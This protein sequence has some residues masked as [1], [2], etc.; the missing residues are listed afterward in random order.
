MKY[1]LGIDFGGGSSKA[2]L[3][4]ENGE[5]KAVSTT[6]YKTYYPQSGYVEQ[7]GEDWYLALKENIKNILQSSNISA[8]DIAAVSL[9]AA[10]HTAVLMDENFNILCPSIYWTETRSL[11]QAEFLN[12]N[13]GDEIMQKTFHKPSTIWTLPQLL[14]I[15]EN[16]GETFE[17]IRKIMFSKDYVRHCLT[18][19]FVTDYIEAEGSMFFNF[20]TKEWDENLCSM[21]HIT[22][23]MLPK[24]LAPSDIAGKVTKEAAEDTGLA[25]G[26]PV[27]CG[28]TDTAMEILAAGA[29][30]EGDIT[31][32]LATAGRICVITDKPYPDRDFVNYSHVT[33]GLWYPGTATKS[34]AASLRW[35]RDTFGGDYKELDEEAEKIEPGCQGLMF[36]P[37]LNGELTPYANPNLCASF[38]GVRAQHTK[39]HFTRAVLEGVA[40][41]LL[42]C[43]KYLDSKGVLYN[44]KAFIIGGGAKS[45]L[46]RQIVS[47]VLGITLLEKKSS[48]SSL[49]SAIMAGVSC[50]FFKNFA[51]AQEKCNS[52]VSETVPN[53]EKHEKYMKLFKKYKAVQSA[54]EPLYTDE[55]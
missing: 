53:M 26:T 50:G 32:K 52:I 43:K 24:V 38:V 48:D 49:G 30:E 20:N 36:H 37:Y 14:W 5:V 42:D 25:E 10:T 31:V 54:L 2:T 35:Y 27:L 8:Q 39:A 15:Y 4:S 34:C 51:D 12:E 9:D 19:D 3:L 6:E 1:V 29:T 7:K 55:I 40:F 22:P 23:D 13:Y 47:D 17:K 33:D 44:E 18:G 46:W 28:T 45:S 21:A 41:S 11:K 16:D